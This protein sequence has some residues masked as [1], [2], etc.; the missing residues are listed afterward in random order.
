[1][2]YN[3][4]PADPTALILGILALVIGIAGCC[5]YGVLAIVPLALSII[6]L[7]MANKSLRG[8]AENPEAYSPQSRSNV[9]TAKV[10][11]IIAIIFN[12]LIMIVFIIFF[13]VYGT[14][15]STAIM[16]GI[17]Q[18]QNEDYYEW[19]N[20]SLYDYEEDDYIVEQDTIQIDSIK[21]EEIKEFENLEN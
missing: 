3:K 8:F 16:E 2:N 18:S 1:M 13:V 19:E 7:V 17:K 14:F 20:D 5:C 4:L 12:G 10:L 15:M 21:V 9:A 6:G 11:N